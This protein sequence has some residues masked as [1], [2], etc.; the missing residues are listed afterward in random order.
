MISIAALVR[1]STAVHR[2]TLP[3]HMWFVGRIQCIGM[4]IYHCKNK[5]VILAAKYLVI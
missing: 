4:Y 1:F 3:L 5:V 2:C